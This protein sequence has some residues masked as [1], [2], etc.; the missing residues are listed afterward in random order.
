MPIYDKNWWKMVR[1]WAALVLVFAGWVDGLTL[2]SCGMEVIAVAIMSQH[3]ASCKWLPDPPPKKNS[4][5]K[6]RQVCTQHPFVPCCSRCRFWLPWLPKPLLLFFSGIWHNSPKQQ[7]SQGINSSRKRRQTHAKQ[8]W[9]PSA[10]KGCRVR[11]PLLCLI[12]SASSK[13]KA[14]EQELIPYGR[15]CLWRPFVPM[16]IKSACKMQCKIKSSHEESSMCTDSNSENT[17]LVVTPALN[18]TCKLAQFIRFMSFQFIS[19]IT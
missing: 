15:S 16:A 13:S 1:S 3:V 11:S 17:T 5:C 12:S 6:L 14:Q 19:Y 9:K 8:H 7:K 18:H 2:S 10:N 4:N